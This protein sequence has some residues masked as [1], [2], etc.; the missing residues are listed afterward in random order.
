MFKGL[1]LILYFTVCF[2]RSVD[3]SY[4]F[5]TMPAPGEDLRPHTF[6]FGLV[7]NNADLCE[8]ACRKQTGCVA[9]TLHLMNYEVR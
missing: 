9:W 8:D 7:E 3:T 5:G 2:E 1:I 6:F 4:V